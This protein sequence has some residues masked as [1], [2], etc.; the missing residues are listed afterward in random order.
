M[1]KVLKKG[2]AE[3]FQPWRMNQLTI[4]NRLVRSATWEGLATPDRGEPTGRLIKALC[5]LALGGVGLIITGY[6][7]IHPWGKGRPRQTGV[8]LDDL[9]TPLRRL[10]DAVHQAGGLV[11][12]QIVH[13]GGQTRA[14]LI[15]RQPLGPSAMTHPFYNQ[16]VDAMSCGQ[17]Q[18]TIGDF[19]RAA[20]RV[21]AAGF[22]GVELHGAHGCL[23]NQ[24]LSPLT[25]QREDDYGG[26]L[27]NRARFALEVLSAARS[28]VGRDF[29]LFV[30]LNSADYQYNGLA[31]EE[32]ILVAR[33]LDLVGVDAIEVSGGTP[34]AGKL[35]AT[36]LVRG[37]GEEGY[38][39]PNA[40][41]IKE[42][43]SCPVISVGGWRSRARVAQAL[44]QVDA[45][46][47]CRPF[48]RQPDLAKRWKNGEEESTCL[49]CNQCFEMGMRQG[50][51]CAQLARSQADP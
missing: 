15:G 27:E 12:V 10:S 25:N 30:K 9:I 36:R 6:A 18:D 17:V 34:A 41:A 7:F 43:V 50:L 8:H 40:V 37:A 3:I 38:F 49:S 19:A 45:V 21:K 28:E 16:P 23:I 11:A 47:L 14:Q 31:L 13:A 32:G 5:D 33:A 35:S 4:P 44:Q 46:A 26:G 1:A 51:G 24:F 20:G 22:D 42:V 2:M 39:L 29:P 48:I